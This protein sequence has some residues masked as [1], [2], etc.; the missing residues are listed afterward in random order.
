MYA[1]TIAATRI[2]WGSPKPESVV[3]PPPGPE[4]L[5]RHKRALPPKA[6][7]APENS[8]LLLLNLQPGLGLLQGPLV[9]VAIKLDGVAAVEACLHGIHTT[10]SKQDH[11][12]TPNIIGT[13]IDLE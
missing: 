7:L 9:P 2:F 4:K 6:R 8:R 12:A 13:C 1:S 5:V 10:I 3:G 11:H